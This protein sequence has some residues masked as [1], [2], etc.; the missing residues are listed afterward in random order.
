[1][2]QPTPTNRAATLSGSE[3]PRMNQMHRHRM[4]KH[5]NIFWIAL[6]LLPHLE[7][8]RIAHRV[9]IEHIGLETTHQQ[10][11]PRNNGCLRA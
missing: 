10:I 1:M 4:L 9:H 7:E 5:R 2:F 8:V 3:A 6:K 11:E